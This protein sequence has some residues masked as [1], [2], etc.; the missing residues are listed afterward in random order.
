MLNIAKIMEIFR[1]NQLFIDSWQQSLLDYYHLPGVTFHM[2]SIH[3]SSSSS[4]GHCKNKDHSLSQRHANL[5]IFLSVNW[6]LL[7]P[8][9]CKL[10]VISWSNDRA[11]CPN[12]YQSTMG[13]YMHLGTSFISWKCKKQDQGFKSFTEVEYHAMCYVCFEIIWLCRVFSELG[14]N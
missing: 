13:W 8:A 3:G 2:Q 9:G 11:G 10:T 12:S 5:R 6:G 7:F 1:L 14:Y 4:Y